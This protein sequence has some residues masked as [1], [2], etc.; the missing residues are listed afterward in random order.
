VIG[1]AQGNLAEQARTMH[2]IGALLITMGRLDAA[3]ELLRSCLSLC[4]DYGMDYA[5]G[6]TL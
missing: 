3:V 6:M 5:E 4:H 2:S 1:H